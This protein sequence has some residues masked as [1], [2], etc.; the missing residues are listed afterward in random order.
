MSIDE[1]SGKRTQR[2]ERFDPSGRDD[3]EQ[4]RDLCYELLRYSARGLLRKDFL[5]RVSET[6]RRHSGCHATEIWVK[7]GSDKHFRCSVT[8]AKKMPFGF[9]L[10]PCP[11]G[12][13]TT[14]PPDDPNEFD[15]EKLCCHVIK[16]SIDRLHPYVTVRGSF[17][18]N[19]LVDAKGSDGPAGQTSQTPILRLGGPYKSVVLLPIRLEEEC[20]G[21]LQLKSKKDAFFS[22]RDIDFYEDISAVLGVA[23]SHQYA[24]VELRERIKEITCLYGIARVV[25]QPEASFDEIIQGIVRL[26]PPAWLYPE[27]TCARIVLNGQSYATENFRESPY[28]QVSDIVVENKRVGF[29]E[30]VYLENKLTLDEG[31]FL[32]EERS[33]IDSVAR[34]VAIYYERAKAEEEKTSL[35]EQLRHADR[36]ATIGQLAAGVAHELNEPLG[37][38]LGFAQLAKKSP[39]LPAQVEKD[40][41]NI[42]SASLNA[43]EIIKKLMTFA[44]QLPPKKEPVNLNDIVN[45]GIYFFEAR[46]MKA[47]IKLVRRLAADLPE[48][49]VDPG[50]INQVLVNL[51]VNAI[52]A[53]PQGGTLTVETS[54]T[55]AEICFSVEDTGTGMTEELKDRIFLPFFTTKDV[56][57]GTGLGLA[58]VH[59]IVTSHGGKILVETKAGKGT[60]FRVHLPFFNPEKPDESKA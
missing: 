21:L 11:L 8:E 34:E 59:G 13:E 9:I 18:A 51:V 16:G 56:D 26:L 36:L 44:R 49:T 46:C 29:V 12:E 28:R 27:I 19:D 2:S 41:E 40:L 10:V 14:P 43:R 38:I 50:Q 37:N 31:P 42:E 20:I 39:E 52:Q 47:G 57:E 3:V 30:V 45:D 60:R 48:I 15:T 58:V 53:M 5:P 24:Q 35:Q 17:W 25:A 1:T 54:A 55:K 4:F 32:A 7:E 6:I 33:L 23:L 22:A